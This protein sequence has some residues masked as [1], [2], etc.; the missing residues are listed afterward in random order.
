M[1]SQITF[2]TFLSQH[3]E[4]AWSATLTTLLRSVHEVDRNAVQIWFAFY[5]LALFQA[6]SQSDDP[7]TLAQRLLMQ[8]NFNLKDQIDSSHTFLYG[9]RYWPQVKAAVQKYASTFGNEKTPLSDQIISVAKSVASDLKVDQSLLVGS[10]HESQLTRF[11]VNVPGT[12][13][14][15]CLV[16]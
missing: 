9:H 2:E 16:S 4:E 1:S 5:P 12:I 6:L 7:E 15:V 13:A 10:M 3:D 8:G 11:C 14:R